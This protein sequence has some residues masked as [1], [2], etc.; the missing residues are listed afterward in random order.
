MKSYT[1]A[2]AE[3]EQCR[4]GVHRKPSPCAGRGGAEEQFGLLRLR[5][6]DAQ[7]AAQSGEKAGREGQ[8][9]ALPVVAAVLITS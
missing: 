5:C 6:R 8:A 2:G 4:A 9:P 7:H 3:Y 1:Q